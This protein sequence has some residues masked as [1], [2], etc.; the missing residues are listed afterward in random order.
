MG[1]SYLYSVCP[2]AQKHMLKVDAACRSRGAMA[3]DQRPE[4]R[5]G[6]EDGEDKDDHTQQR[7]GRW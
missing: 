4:E 5:W 1:E 3:R 7:S 2:L 6:E